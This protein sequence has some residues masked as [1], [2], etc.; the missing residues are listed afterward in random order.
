VNNELDFILFFFL[1]YFIF[2]IL[3]YFTFEFLFFFFILNLGRRSNVTLC[4]IFVTV[5][6]IQSCDIEKNIENTRINNII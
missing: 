1:F 6:I 4:V 5:I 3:F 2:L